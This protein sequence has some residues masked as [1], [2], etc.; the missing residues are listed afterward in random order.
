MVAGGTVTA[1]AETEPGR[2]WS[3]TVAPDREFSGRLT[4][5]L[6]AGAAWDAQDNP[7]AAARYA[8]AVVSPVRTTVLI[9]TLSPEPVNGRFVAIIRFARPVTGF[10]LSDVEVTGARRRIC[11]WSRRRWSGR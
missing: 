9:Y 7:S 10:E 6:G 3:A 1:L 5:E 11:G 4:I 2:V 8:R